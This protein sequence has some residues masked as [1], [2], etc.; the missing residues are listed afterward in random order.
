MVEG[1]EAAVAGGVVAEGF[2]KFLD[3]EFGPE[4]FGDV[5]FGVGDLPEEEVGDAQFASGA[6]EEVGVGHA[7][8]VEV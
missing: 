7:G 8:G 6:D 3:G 2:V 5:E 1:S 4:D